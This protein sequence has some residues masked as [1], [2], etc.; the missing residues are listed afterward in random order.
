MEPQ[1][2][3]KHWDGYKGSLGSV[4]NRVSVFLSRLLSK[5]ANRRQA[6]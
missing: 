3:W 4:G 5:A 6:S 2:N 1:T